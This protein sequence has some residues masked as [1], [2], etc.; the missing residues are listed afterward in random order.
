MKNK[1]F[2][3]PLICL[4]TFSCFSQ[5]LK[6]K[7]VLIPLD[8]TIGV[9]F[10]RERELADLVVDGFEIDNK[11][12]FYF[13]GGNLTC[14]AEFSGNKQLF[15]KTYREFPSSSIYIYNNKLYT[16]YN[17]GDNNNLFVIDPSN[18]LVLKRYNKI[19]DT[20]FNSYKFVDSSLVVEF[21]TFP[22]SVYHLYSLN[23]KYINNAIGRYNIDTLIV[24]RSDGNFQANYIG[25]WGDSN[26]FWDIVDEKNN[27]V[28]KFWLVNKQGKIIATKQ[29]PN[30]S[31]IFGNDFYEDFPTEHRKVRNGNLYVLGRKGKNAVITIVPLNSFFSK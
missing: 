2:F 7:H 17:R 29:L 18:G 19:A 1:F 28:E 10:Y 11:G 30:N 6:E 27:Q 14:L 26:V 12:N 9:P 23:G 5:I 16:F 13:M 25:K 20:H 21:S 4:V 31:V 22:K 8:N 15:R 24:P 3:T